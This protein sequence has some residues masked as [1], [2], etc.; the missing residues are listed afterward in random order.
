GAPG[1]APSASVS[2]GV[3]GTTPSGP[4]Q[5]IPGTPGVST[6]SGP[7]QIIQSIQPS[8]IEGIPTEKKSP[9]ISPQAFFTGVPG[10]SGDATV[11]RM[12]FAPGGQAY[13]AGMPGSLIQSVPGGE[14]VPG[15]M[16]QPSAV[17]GQVAV[18]PLPSGLSTVQ[19]VPGMPA[20][21]QTPE[22]GAPSVTAAP[23]GQAVSGVG[24][25][26]AVLSPPETKGP[27]EV[28]AKL[29]SDER[30]DVDMTPK[31]T[32]S[33]EAEDDI[34]T[35]T[36]P[37]LAPYNWDMLPSTS[38]LLRFR[39]MLNNAKKAEEK[40]DYIKALKVYEAVQNQKT[41]QDD[42]LALHV[43]N[44]QIEAVNRKARA[45]ISDNVKKNKKL[46]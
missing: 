33:F 44:D 13:F 2:P 17:P 27:T 34:V 25:A 19:Q 29:S 39:H 30:L 6:S 4:V 21:Q 43:L 38:S 42:S 41:I 7:A 32:Q 31:G 28:E 1:S 14:A 15:V 37:N 10:T 23:G 8:R 45:Q 18:A 24:A 5:S 11:G 20:Q 40:N 26:T 46:I 36:S 35:R 12:T 16:M 3:S 22:P 9:D